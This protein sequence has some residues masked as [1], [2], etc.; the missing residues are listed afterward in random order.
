MHNLNYFNNN[1][2]N[3]FKLKLTNNDDVINF[4][5]TYTCV[6]RT[7]ILFNHCPDE[8]SET[9]GQMINS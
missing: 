1:N 4:Y 8:L 2:I 3:I 9:D 7:S 5:V 6:A